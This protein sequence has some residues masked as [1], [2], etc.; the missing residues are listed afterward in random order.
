MNPHHEH[1]RLSASFGSLLLLTTCSIALAQTTPSNLEIGVLQL[2]RITLKDGTVYEGVLQSRN[3]EEIEFVEI[4][5]R[6]GAAMSAAV[7]ILGPSQVRHYVALPENKRQTLLK[8]VERLRH[9]FAIEAGNLQRISLVEAS[10]ESSHAWEYTGTWFQ[11]TSTADEE[12]TRRCV[13]RI[14]QVFRAFGQMFPTTATTHRPLRIVLYGS[15][16]EYQTAMRTLGIE[17]ENLAF[18]AARERTIFAGAELVSYSQRL[19]DIRAAHQQTLDNLASDEAKFRAQL[20]TY[21]DKLAAQGYGREQIKEE[22]AL[23]NAAWKRERLLLERQISET[24]RRND[25]TFATV[26]ERM[27]KRLYHEAFH[28]YFADHVVTGQSRTVDRWLNEGLAQIF[29]A[30]QLDGDMLR[31]DAPNATA[32]AQ[33]QRDLASSDP[34]PLPELL[35]STDQ[36]FLAAHTQITANRH[37]AYAW[38][39]AY[40]LAIEKQW[41]TPDSLATFQ[42]A[43]D[44]QK[45]H[46]FEALVG[47]PIGEF[48][49]EW[50][51]AMLSL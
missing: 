44:Q 8:H 11:L 47:K 29:E 16:D 18:Y 7:R 21:S 2:E 12:S 25:A 24:D 17:I 49:R 20:K 40:Y 37:Y 34:L 42:S 41:I 36:D 39:L 51:A 50:H 4:F 1:V 3:R 5:L 48:E 28:A 6:P 38:G 13:V 33:L 45:L 10:P 31:I 14:E 9:R 46:R 19:R 32:L 15:V 35:L 22:L 23:R 30:G 43:P 26:T 27:F